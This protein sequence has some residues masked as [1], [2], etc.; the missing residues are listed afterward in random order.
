MLFSDLGFL[1]IASGRLRFQII[2]SASTLVL[3]FSITDIGAHPALQFL[4]FGTVLSI[5]ITCVMQPCSRF[6]FGV[7]GHLVFHNMGRSR[8]CCSII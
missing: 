4:F 3:H 2:R 6:T 5:V 7:F 8:S 1:V